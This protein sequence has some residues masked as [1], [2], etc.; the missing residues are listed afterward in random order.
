MLNVRAMR[1]EE[2]AEVAD[3]IY[4]S[5]N[6]WYRANG[7]ST[8]FTAAPE[9]TELFCRVYE[10]LDPGCCLVAEYTATGRL[11]GSCF[12]HPRETHVSLGIMNVHPNYFGLGVA[13]T[14]LHAIIEVA[15]NRAQP[16]RLVSSAM[17]L[18]S[19]SLYTRAGFVPQ[20]AFQD[21]TL[22]VP[23]HGFAFDSPEAHYVRPATLEDVEAMT[24]LEGEI[25]GIRREKDFHYFLENRDSIWHASVLEAPG[26]GLDGFLISVAHPASNMIGPGIAR[27]EAQA[28][29]L[30]AAEL[31]YNQ[32]RQPVW[33]VPVTCT[34]LVQQMYD[35]GA[36][37]CELH[38][39][40]VR[41]AWTPPT[42]V[43]MP[44]F[45]PETG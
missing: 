9:S 24:A 13:R 37:N 16:L 29:A 18:D 33:L 34:S 6:Y 26:G 8:I 12:Y 27:T 21:M 4:V 32:G 39:A 15:E 17:N 38:F 2:W 40:Q 41:G 45:M 3:L 23:E 42:G 7:K 25:S 30:I 5:T 31:D 36:K 20:M 14:L 44:T 1:R 19:F 22:P 10:D 28:A 35:W 11:A 43:I